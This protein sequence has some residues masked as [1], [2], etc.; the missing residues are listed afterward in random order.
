M[1][2]IKSLSLGFL[3]SLQLAANGQTTILTLDNVPLSTLCNEIWT[4]QNLSISFVSSTADDCGPGACYFGVE[5][6]FVW[7]YPSRLTIDLSSLQ[8]I[9][10]VEVDIVS[11]CGLINP[12]C[13]ESFLLDST[14][15]II[16]N[17][18]NTINESLETLTIENPTEGFI[19]QL[20]ISS[21]ESQIHEIR[22]HQNILS[23]NQ[24]GLDNKEITI[25]PNPTNGKLTIDFAGIIKN[26]E[27]VD[28]L[29]RSVLAPV[30]I[31]NKSVDAT[32]LS[33]GKYMARITTDTNQ[34]LVKEFAVQK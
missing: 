34:I 29:G 25:Y 12:Q 31:G 24:M 26:V 7:L 22:I 5:P 6:T 1:K 13:T 27:V 11:Y 16:D 15:M 33:T 4:E 14:G 10:N 30:A 28:M 23:T 21:C 32:G 3:L 19:S 18:V 8:N 2:L 17:V 9:Q 20:A